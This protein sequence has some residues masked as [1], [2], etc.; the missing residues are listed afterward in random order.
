MKKEKEDLSKIEFTSYGSDVFDL[1]AGGGSPFGKVINIIGDNSV[2]KSLVASEIIAHARKKYGKDLLWYYDDAEAGYSFDSKAIWGFEMI[3]DAMVPSD[4]IEDFALHVDRTL[5]KMK[6]GQKLIY[7]VDSFDGLTSVGEQEEFEEKM[8]AIE[9]DKDVKGTYGQAKAKGTNQFFRIMA[10][11]IK[12]KD[13]LLI[14]ISQVRENI[15]AGP[16]APKLRRNGGKSLDLYAC[17]I[18][19]LAVAE[20]YL[21]KG[22]VIGVGIQIKNTKNKVGKPYREGYM[23]LVF[24]YGIDNI[25]SNLKYFYELKT[26]KGKDK[27]KIGTI[28]LDWDGEKFSFNKLISHIEEKGLESKLTEKVYKKWNDFENSIST[29][30]KRRFE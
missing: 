11:K 7:I 16:Y 19:W 10:N 15:G 9:K 6:K 14:I 8:T 5:S 2:G 25:S 4:T 24:D 29:E 18:F 28:E 27:E 17:Q 3:T 21:R 26:D 13:C 22:T 30:R 1:I 20:K 12:D 23:D